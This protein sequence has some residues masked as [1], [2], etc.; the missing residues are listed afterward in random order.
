MF[1]IPFSKY[2]TNVRVISLTTTLI[3]VAFFVA[4]SLAIGLGT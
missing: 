4:K 2:G 3:V 1:N